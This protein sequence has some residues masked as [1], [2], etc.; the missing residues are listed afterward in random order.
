MS[1]VLW[2]VVV[3]QV[4]RWIGVLVLGVGVWRGGWGGEGVWG[5]EGGGK[6]E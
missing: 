3:V 6:E 5:G 4:E 2:V 1:E